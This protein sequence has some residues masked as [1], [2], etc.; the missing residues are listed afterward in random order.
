M[1]DPISTETAAEEIP[2]YKK[3]LRQ[4]IRILVTFGLLF[5]LFWQVRWSNIVAAIEGIN[6]SLFI[7]ACFLW[8]PT[9]IF[10]FYKWKLFAREAGEQV[11]RGDLH[12]SYWVGYT[13]GVITPGR[14]G[15]IGRALALHN[16]SMTRAISLSVIERGYTALVINSIGLISV[17]ILPMIGWLPP[18]TLPNPAIMSVIA[19]FG[20]GMLGFGIFPRIMIRPLRR[21][22][23]ILPAKEKL[24]KAVETLATV[25][26]FRAF[27]ALLLSIASLSS[28]LIQYVILIR[29][30]GASIPLFSGMLAGLLNFFLKGAMPFS[31]GSLGVGEWTA[32]YC[33]KGLGVEPS[34]AVAG[35]LL[36][37]TINV[38]VPS[39]IGLPFIRT[40]RVPVIS[41]TNLTIT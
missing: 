18:V 39:L 20:V 24:L 28:S 19:V 4:V 15:Q 33:F 10:Q 37:F 5:L 22:I 30:M 7:M 9:Q 23:R 38:F 17:A 31:V 29:A 13:L 12:R 21:L 34:I 8:I 25:T 27:M 1:K 3:F 14:I 16:C 35:S 11:S 32:I 6:P 40:M 2:L 26:P 41:G 36:L